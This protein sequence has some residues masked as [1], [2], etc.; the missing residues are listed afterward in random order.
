M[1]ANGSGQAQPTI[2]GHLGSVGLL[3]CVPFFKLLFSAPDGVT[4]GATLAG[5]Q[6]DVQRLCQLAPEAKLITSL[7]PQI[8]GVYSAHA[9]MSMDGE[10][11]SKQSQSVVCYVFFAKSK[12]RYSKHSAL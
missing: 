3:P 9:M 8:G 7:C 11:P 12:R 6:L 10:W 5:M 4:G 1:P 2:E